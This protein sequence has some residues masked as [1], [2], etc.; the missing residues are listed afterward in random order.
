VRGWRGV[1][2]IGIA[3]MALSVSGCKNVDVLTETYATLA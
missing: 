3:V 2:A 1:L